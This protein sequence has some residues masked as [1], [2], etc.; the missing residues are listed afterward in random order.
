MN[1]FLFGSGI[2]LMAGIALVYYFWLYESAMQKTLKQVGEIH[3][4][5]PAVTV[6]LVVLVWPAML[7]SYSRDLLRRFRN[8][9]PRSAKSGVMGVIPSPSDL[10]FWEEADRRLAAKAAEYLR[11]H[12][13]CVHCG[14]SGT[15]IQ[16]AG[17]I[18]VICSSCTRRTCFTD[19]SLQY[20]EEGAA[21]PALCGPLKSKGCWVCGGQ[22]EHWMPMQ[23]V[24]SGPDWSE[25]QSVCK[26][27]V[28]SGRLKAK[29]S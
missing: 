22:V 3:P 14:K 1:H 7:I 8:R 20:P 27:C 25:M 21:P 2:Y 19:P 12:R 16:E 4:Y 23:E 26:A 6:A 11:L 24:A 17:S 5:A 9:R 15:S 28:E 29:R 18:W 10:K 13:H